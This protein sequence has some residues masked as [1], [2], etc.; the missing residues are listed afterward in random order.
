VSDLIVSEFVSLNGVIE[1]NGAKEDH[2]HGGWQLESEYGD[3]HYQYK[4]RELDEAGSLLIGR[5]TYE[6]FTA[7]WSESEGPL[8]DR[9]NA[10][11][12]YVVSST[13]AEPEWANTTVIAFEDI[14]PL[15]RTSDGPILVY[16][17]GRLAHALIE[18]ELVD[19]YRAMISP[20][21]IADGQR[22][23]PSVREM[24]RLR[25]VNA[26]PYDSGVLLASYRPAHDDHSS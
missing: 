17:S 11:R 13:L 19:E 7:A 23:F 14:A 20:V 9:M 22:M 10:I 21:L 3:D 2:P 25:L 4:E 26:T 5:K 18:Q 12:K 6:V 16:G 15:K 24:R 1:A 8:A